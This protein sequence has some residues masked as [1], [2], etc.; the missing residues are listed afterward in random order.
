M[1]TPLHPNYPPIVDMNSDNLLMNTRCR[2][3]QAL[4]FKAPVAE[5]SRLLNELDSHVIRPLDGRNRLIGR[6]R[7]TPTFQLLEQTLI[8]F[9]LYRYE[10][11]TGI[12]TDNTSSGNECC[13][14][15]PVIEAGASPLTHWSAWLNP[16]HRQG[17]NFFHLARWFH[18]DT[19]SPSP[20]LNSTANLGPTSDKDSLVRIVNDDDTLFCQI[21]NQGSTLFSLTGNLGPG[22][23]TPALNHSRLWQET[24][25]ITSVHA[26][27][28]G[29][30]RLHL[31]PQITMTYGDRPHISPTTESL[32]SALALDESDA[33]FAWS[34]QQLEIAYYSSE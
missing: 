14:A 28:T 5:V 3:F 29:R 12:G 16:W 23:P 22:I 20:A 27:V 10:S 9:A 6:G 24:D 1:M 17:V 13:I 19:G 25:E 4:F 7:L 32:L 21:Q 18:T 8:V 2:H 34:G 11:A 26:K 15:L 33:L 31:R 30:P